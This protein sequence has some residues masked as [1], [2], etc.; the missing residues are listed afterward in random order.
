MTSS[1]RL[2]SADRHLVERFSYGVTPALAAQVRAAGS[3][4]RWLE[5]QLSGQV[6]ED[7][8]MTLVPVWFA[9][10]GNPPPLAQR[11]N[12]SGG[13]PAFQVDTEVI[14]RTVTRR[15]LSNHQVRER[16]ADAMSNLLYVPALGGR[17]FAWRAHFDDQV[18]RAQV[19]STYPA[20]LR[21]ATFHPAM[22]TFLDGDQNARG[23]INEN[24]ARELL[25]LHTVGRATYTERDVKDLARLLTGF[26]VDPATT[27]YAVG[28]DPGRHQTGRVRVVGWTHANSAADGRPALRSLLRH[29][30][31]HPATA[32]RVA[33]RLC[34]RFVADSPDRAIVEAVA[35][36]YRRTGGDL[37]AC[38]R[39]LVAHPSFAASRDALRLTPADDV[40]RSARVL[41]LRPI[42]ATP[43]SFVHRVVELGWSMGQMSYRWPAPDGWPEAS[44]R[45]LGASR[46]LR[47]WDAHYL[48]AG[49]ASDGSKAVLAPDK[50]SQLPDRWPRT[51]A[52][53]TRHQA[54]LLLGR[55][56]G[57]RLVTAASQALQLPADHAF[58]S[59]REVDDDTYHLLR[60][61]VLN[62]PSGLLR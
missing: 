34:Q 13:R 38:V 62:D 51:L 9:A 29:L 35:A 55:R 52:S 30:A 49:L 43:A 24:H 21:A 5:Q 40:V 53:L 58:A 17:T 32:R 36:T 14:A 37:R 42:G 22:V 27:G 8:S 60:G 25:E 41:G 39:S 18:I 23:A 33:T 57:D 11:L 20:M 31:L 3:G 16:L 47:G 56:A 6:A 4:R 45:Y 19:F 26:T 46:M 2:P 28:Y 44:A 12:Q 7:T 50:A 15:I 10:L 1:P 61:T 54:E 48:L 59:A